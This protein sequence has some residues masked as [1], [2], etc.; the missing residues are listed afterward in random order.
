[1][2][3]IHVPRRMTLKS[4]G[5]TESVVAALSSMQQRQGHA[6][7]IHTSRA[8]DPEPTGMIGTVPVHRHAHHYPWLQIDP[9]TRDQMDRVGGNLV[10][11]ELH[12]TLRR[13]KDANVFHLHTAKRMGGIVR[14]AARHHGVPYVVT[15]HGGLVGRTTAPVSDEARVP[16]P[17][18]EWGRAL[19]WMVGSR[20]VLH[21]AAAVTY[22]APEDGA[23]LR[24]MGISNAVHVPNGVD[25]AR[26][27]FGDGARFRRRLG[28]APEARLALCMGRIDPQKNQRG[29]LP[30]LAALTANHDLHLALVGPV[31]DPDYAEAIDRE[32]TRLGI[33]HR[34]HRVG[35]IGAGS[36]EL[37][38]AYHA[39]DVL[40]V[41]SIHEPFGIVILEAWAAGLPVVAN[42]VGGIPHFARSG[43]DSLLVEP[44]DALGWHRALDATLAHG[45]AVKARTARAR[46]RARTEFDWALIADRYLEL[47]GELPS[48]RR[49]A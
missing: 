42:R 17:K 25:A 20:R 24:E 34:V 30:V 9:R 27:R 31:T 49:A 41:P 4:W 33:G 18:L 29:L 44:G 10:S 28:V 8:L 43:Q 40:T 5:G 26:F 11:L 37:V 15:L 23:R 45:D 3:I 1:M 19:G 47:Y 36:Q 6:P 16:A 39:A 46:Q 14:A 13:M 22:M 48:L 2:K 21:D 38:D 7:E 12:R 32:A 35:G